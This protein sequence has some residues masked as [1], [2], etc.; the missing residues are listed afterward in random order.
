VD[1]V[2][3]ILRRRHRNRPFYREVQVKDGKLFLG[4]KWGGAFRAVSLLDS[5]FCS[6]VLI[7][8]FL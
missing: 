4:G 5:A 2:D 1:K 6:L 8:V 7:W 3:L